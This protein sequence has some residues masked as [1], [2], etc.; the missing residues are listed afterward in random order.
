MSIYAAGA[1]R[2]PGR[3]AAIDLAYALSQ[4]A[5]VVYFS[6]TSQNYLPRRYYHETK[7]L[8]TATKQGIIKT[9][10]VYADELLYVLAVPML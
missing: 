5:I 4:N 7:S 6:L 8:T 9:S 3:H 1:R 10:R 2:M